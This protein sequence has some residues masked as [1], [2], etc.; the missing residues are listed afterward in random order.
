MKWDVGKSL[1]LKGL[2]A[3]EIFEEQF[4]GKSIS[5][6]DLLIAPRSLDFP[7]EAISLAA[8]LTP[9]IN[10]AIPFV[11]AP[12]DTV[13]TARMGIGMADAGGIGII[14]ANFESLQQKREVEKVKR[15]GLI[16][17]PLVLSLNTRL[18]HL[19]CIRKEYSHVPITDDGKPNGRFIGMI[20]KSFRPRPHHET[21]KDCLD[22]EHMWPIATVKISDILYPNGVVNAQRALD[23][24]HEN[25]TTA[26]AVI[27]DEKNFLAGLLV[28]KDLFGA[29]RVPAHATLDERGR[30]RVGAAITTFKEDYERRVPKLID[31]DTDVLCIDTAHGHSKF[32]ADAIKWTKDTF[33]HIEI[34]AGN[35]STAEGAAFLIDAG[36]D[37][38]RVGNGTGG[39]CST[40]RITRT[41]TASANGVWRAAAAAHAHR[42][43]AIADGGIRNS[44]DILVA[45]A[46]GADTVMAGTYLAAL[47]ES[48]APLKNIIIDGRQSLRKAHRG[49]ASEAAQRER[50]VARYGAEHVRMPEG[51]EVYLEPEQRTLAEYTALTM[52]GVRQAFAYLGVPSIPELHEK[53]RSGE[54]RFDVE[55]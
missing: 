2:T 40:H 25:A 53:V 20:T 17:E 54:I 38:I 48:A 37:A 26:L 51:E 49:M 45:L 13:T 4:R 41:G 44:G 31:A 47:P 39:A 19:E 22:D 11:S 50:V 14:H 24:M 9:K 16:T 35:V 21:I 43:P 28:A 52:A 27:N 33:P 12:M 29:Q 36:A 15:G 10:L 7:Q 3:Q 5:F 42:V 30:R 23:L 18:E 1:R 6:G 46:L 32:A 34:I 55:L 8:R